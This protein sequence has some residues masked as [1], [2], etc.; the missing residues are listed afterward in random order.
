MP[1]NNP[2]IFPPDLR[3]GLLRFK[4]VCKAWLSQIEN[5][6]FITNHY[7]KALKP[8]I[9]LLACLT[10]QHERPAM[11]TSSSSPCNVII[12]FYRDWDGI[13]LWNPAIRESKVL[14]IYCKW[15]LVGFGFDSEVNDY[16]IMGFTGA[17]NSTRIILYGLSSD[18][19]IEIPDDRSCGHR[20]C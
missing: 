1:S 5:S 10:S 14:Q 17:W 4:C 2:G 15:F 11:S 8:Y 9:R 16:K 3:S 20:I 18:N 6:N 12:C 19:W 7:N 13:T